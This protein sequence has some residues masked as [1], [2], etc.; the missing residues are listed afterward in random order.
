[1]RCFYEMNCFISLHYILSTTYFST[2]NL[3][4]FAKFKKKH[5]N[6][7]VA[8]AES[9]IKH[10]EQTDTNAEGNV[11]TETTG[12]FPN[13]LIFKTF[14]FFYIYNLLQTQVLNK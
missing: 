14:H 8:P 4:I 13:H 2:L 9:D 10:P 12:V 11:K 5:F 7:F 1:M 6:I 3:V